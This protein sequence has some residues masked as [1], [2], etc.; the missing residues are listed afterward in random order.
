MGTVAAAPV[1]IKKSICDTCG[2]PKSRSSKTAYVYCDY[3]GTLMDFDLAKACESPAARPGPA[4]E[5]IVAERQ[6]ALNDALTSGDRERY[7]GLQKEIFDAFVNHC[8]DSVPLR[9]KDPEY[10]KKYVHYMAM[11]AVV[12]AF[13]ERSRELEAEV[14]RA[15]AQLQFYQL[16]ESGQVRVEGNGWKVL[17]DAVL[18]Q[19]EYQTEIYQREDVH[20]ACP[21]NTP[22]SVLKRMGLSAFVQGW[23][24]VLDQTQSQELLERTQMLGEYLEI[25]AR[26]SQAVERAC[27]CCKSPVSVLPGAKFVVCEACG[28]RLCVDGEIKCKSCGNL[29]AVASERCSCPFCQTEVRKVGAMWEMDTSGP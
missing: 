25:P 8:P 1:R 21:D 10:R 5:A 18:K 16:P 28:H 23:L 9:V 11:Y 20:R 2:A 26:A 15:T 6:S 24:P 3:C 14:S 29:L 17:R 4:Y 13:D 19:I 27:S 7:L 12:M 22:F